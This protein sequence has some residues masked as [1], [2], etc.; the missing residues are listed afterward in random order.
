MSHEGRRADRW[1]KPGQPLPGARGTRGRAVGVPRVPRGTLPS[2]VSLL[3][4]LLSTRRP[5][6]RPPPS[7]HR[8]RAGVAEDPAR[9]WAAT[10]SSCAWPW[11]C[12][13]GSRRRPSGARGRR[14]RSCDASC[15]S[16][17]P[18]S[19]PAPAAGSPAPA[20]PAQN[21]ARG[22]PHRA[23][24]GGR[25]GGWPDS[26]LSHAG[27]TLAGQRVGDAGARL[28]PGPPCTCRARCWSQSPPPSWG[29]SCWVCRG[30]E[31]T[32][33]GRVQLPELLL[34]RGGRTQRGGGHTPVLRATK[35]EPRLSCTVRAGA[36]L[37]GSCQLGPRQARS[38][39]HPTAHWL[40]G[41]G[42]PGVPSLLATY[43]ALSPRPPAQP[44]AGGGC[45]A[46]GR[47][48]PP[49]SPNTA[50]PTASSALTQ[51]PPAL[52]GTAPAPA[53]GATTARERCP[54]QP[55]P[56]VP[57]AAQ[58]GMAGAG[59]AEGTLGSGRAGVSG[60]PHPLPPGAPPHCPASPQAPAAAHPPI[61][62]RQMVL[63]PTN[64]PRAGAGSEALGAR[65]P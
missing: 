21:G 50:A 41:Q 47:P 56:A 14:R 6:G 5:P 11:S 17:S 12:R 39:L 23:A 32:G 22:P 30:R 62:L 61:T 3:T 2:P 26:T 16:R 29:G 24:A 63:T 1:V 52:P 8:R 53:E 40:S 44:G 4:G 37:P 38:P 48:M 19:S 42:C 46:W 64:A 36:S 31:Q 54:G 35:G 57:G 59:G 34:A 15:S 60:V 27:T 9:R 28:W 55:S 20:W 7:R 45:E 25:D 58:R 49:A 51:E 18:S 43:C 13:R 33:P 10:K 65:G